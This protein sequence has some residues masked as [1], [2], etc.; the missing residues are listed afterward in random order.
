M[1]QADLDLVAEIYPVDLSPEGD[2][3]DLAQVI[4]DPEW[5]RSVADKF[6]PD[7]EV[8]FLTPPGATL[9]VMDRDEFKGLEGLAE[10]WRIWMEP[11]DSFRVKGQEMIDAGE[12]RVLF[13]AQSTV[14]AQDSGIEI[15]QQTA[16]LHRVQNGK[17]TSIDYYLDH[18][19]ARRDAGL[20]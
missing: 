7:L 12:G 4:D 1:S 6:S 8:R 2:E 9:Q 19:Q 16:A 20:E 15:T 3:F 5:R 14:R 13:L 11:W 17:V 10:G 18:A